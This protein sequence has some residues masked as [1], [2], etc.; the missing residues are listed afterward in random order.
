MAGRTLKTPITVLHLIR[1]MHPNLKRKVRTALT[2]ILANPALGRPLRAEL[3]GL[4][5]WRVGQHRVIYRPDAA[6]AEIIAIGPRR[7]IYEDT[8]K[9]I[10]FTRRK[11]NVPMKK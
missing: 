3:T 9:Q 8:A 4:W 1:K 7:T 2:D 6:G 10:V 5:S 11:N